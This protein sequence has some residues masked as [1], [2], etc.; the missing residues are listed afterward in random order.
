[1]NEK[2]IVELRYRL[3]KLEEKI[4]VLNKVE[5]YIL[6]ALIPISLFRLYIFILGLSISELWIMV[7]KNKTQ[8]EID[9]YKNKLYEDLED[10]KIEVDDNLYKLYGN[11]ASTDI[12]EGEE[13]IVNAKRDD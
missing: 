7:E 10:F 9:E 4:D 2:D 8:K 11:F 5:K 13:Y 6:I 3:Y 12:L 1:M